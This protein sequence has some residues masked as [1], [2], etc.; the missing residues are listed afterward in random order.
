MATKK[1]SRKDISKMSMREFL[2]VS[3]EPYMRLASYL[4]PYKARFLVGMLFGALFGV[5]NGALVLLVKQVLPL[6]FPDGG[7][8]TL[9]FPAWT[10]IHVAPIQS[11]QATLWQVALVCARVPLLMAVR[12]FFSYMNAYCLLWVSQR[13]LDDIRQSLFR[14]IMDQSLEFFNRAKSGELVQT[15]FNQTRVAQQALTQISGDIVKQPFAI[16]SAL[17]AL[18]AVDGRFTLVAFLVFPLCLLPVLI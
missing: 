15:V 17:I 18:F 6:V 14:H 4:K 1:I 12:G 7:E 5:A 16:L 11:G 9:K 10:H 8:H 3:R 2:R 13:V